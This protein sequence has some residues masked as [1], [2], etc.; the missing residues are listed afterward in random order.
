MEGSEGVTYQMENVLNNYHENTFVLVICLPMKKRTLNLRRRKENTLF[1]STK[2]TDLP[3]Y[4]CE[5]RGKMKRCRDSWKAYFISVNHK[6][7]DRVVL[8]RSHARINTQRSSW[9]IPPRVVLGIAW[10][11]IE[12]SRINLCTALRPRRW[13]LPPASPIPC[14]AAF[15]VP[16]DKSAFWRFVVGRYRAL[17]PGLCLF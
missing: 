16:H 4:I 3:G 6:R 14:G 2:R 15:V 8:C 7:I 13:K 17:V 5:K 1:L 12:I 11:E 9:L 10:S